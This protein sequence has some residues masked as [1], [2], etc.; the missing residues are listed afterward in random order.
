VR[1]PAF[2]SASQDWPWVA[3]IAAAFALIL[4]VNPVGFVGGGWDDWHYLDAA[5]C[6]VRDGPCLPANHWQG[7][8]PIIAPLAVAISALGE[9]RWVVGLPSLLYSLGC[10]ALLAWVTNRLAGRP[11]GYVAALLLLVTPAFAVGLLDPSVEAA[12]LFFLLA[13]ACLFAL[14]AKN[15]APILLFAAGLCLS[16]AFQVRETSAAAMPIAL[17]V[18]WRLAGADR[19]SWIAIFAGLLLPVA[20]ELLVFWSAAGD[21]L[22]RR[23]LSVAHTHI[24]SSELQGAIDRSRPPFFN[25]DLIAQWRHEPGLR[26]H[27]LVDGLAN[28][29]VNTRAGVTIAASALLFAMYRRKLE[30]SE[31]QWVSWILIAALYWAGF[32]IYVLAIDPKPRMMMVPIALTAVTL[33]IMLRSRIAARDALPA[34]TAFAASLAVGAW[35]IVAH[36]QF[37]TSETAVRQWVARFPGKIE[38]TET[39]RRHLA[40]TAAGTDLADITSN[41]P[42]LVLRLSIRCSE[43]ARNEMGGALVTLDR[44]PMSLFD[45]PHERH[46]DNVCLFRYTR[47]LPASAIEQAP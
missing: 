3:A 45:P 9:S 6:W 32:L 28:L 36:P 14:F 40:L 26:V 42:L 13:A 18:T 41:R 38:T 33:A 15:R 35:G 43:W 25:P 31:R 19:A 46:T 20:V 12:E 47:P 27:W 34:W 37:R 17:I 5:R 10:L 1:R 7:R 30:L 16:L 44:V 2:R 29:V 4:V 11:V 22:W 8:W 24:P 21:P 23:Q 39:M